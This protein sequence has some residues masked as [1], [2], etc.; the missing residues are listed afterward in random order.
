[1]PETNDVIAGMDA[2]S[3][4]RRRWPPARTSWRDPVQSLRFPDYV[5]AS[6]RTNVHTCPAGDPR[7]PPLQI[8][9]NGAVALAFLPGPVIYPEHMD[10]SA[11]IFRLH[12][13]DG[14]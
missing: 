9:K 11:K 1:M 12:S 10:P 13:A 2:E 5:P 7:V 8:H 4:R 14:Q 3:A 6:F